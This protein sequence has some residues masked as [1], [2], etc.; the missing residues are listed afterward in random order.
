MSAEEKLR[1]ME[2]LW[3]SLSREEA[4]LESPPWHKEALRETAA[5]HDAGKEQPIHWDAAKRELR[6]RAE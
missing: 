3:E 5:R 4:R 2:A 6:K 1:L